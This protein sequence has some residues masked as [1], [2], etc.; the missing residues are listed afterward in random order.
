MHP[1]LLHIGSLPIHTYGFLIAIGF[2]LAVAVIKRLAARSGLDVEKVL[3]LTFWC[4]AI[5]FVG[6]RLLFVITRFDSFMEDPVSIFKVWEGGLV[7]F[8]GPLA[9][10]PFA[11][12][13]L[14]KHKLQLWRVMDSMVPGLV[15]AHAFGRFGCLAAGCCYGKPTGSDWGIK[16]YSELVDKALQGVPLHPTQLYE[17][18]SLLILFFG[19]LQVFKKRVF[20]GQVTLVYFMAYPIIRSIIEVFR[21]DT[22]R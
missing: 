18:T 22:I 17:S 20:D 15:I 16:L 14:R 13:Y 6:A 9:A 4:L 19:L 5:G 12:W 10:V 1:V 21:G 3:D 7:F 8:G 11:V 2:L